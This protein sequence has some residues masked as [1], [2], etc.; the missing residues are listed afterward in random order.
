M[1]TTSKLPGKEST[2]LRHWRPIEPVEPR[3][4]MCLM[5]VIYSSLPVVSG[6]LHR[7]S[8]FPERR[9]F[10]RCLRNFANL[11][12]GWF[13]FCSGA[14]TT[15]AGMVWNARLGAEISHSSGPRQSAGGP[16]VIPRREHSDC[17]GENQKMRP[18]HRITMVVAVDRKST[19]L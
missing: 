19:R 2:T 3:M 14:V 18:V 13:S 8:A 12:E 1:A 17:E 9:Q 11:T 7:T 6:A 5:R 15:F 4:A 16:A 10:Y